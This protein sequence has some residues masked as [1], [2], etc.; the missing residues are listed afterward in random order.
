MISFNLYDHDIRHAHSVKVDIIYWIITGQSVLFF[1]TK[2]TFVL[3]DEYLWH[4]AGIIF[5]LFS[6]SVSS[7]ICKFNILV[8]ICN[9]TMNMYTKKHEIYDFV[10]KNE[11][12]TALQLSHRACNVDLLSNLTAVVKKLLENIVFYKNTCFYSISFWIETHSV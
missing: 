7:G 3:S 4:L 5:V 1:A 10:P 8:D 12:C 9:E 6:R 11:V 2:V